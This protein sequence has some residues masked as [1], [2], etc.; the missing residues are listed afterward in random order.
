MSEG[1][2]EIQY[3]R[4]WEDEQRQE[5]YSGRCKEVEIRNFLVH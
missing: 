5:H 1:E 3:K 4:A 2:R